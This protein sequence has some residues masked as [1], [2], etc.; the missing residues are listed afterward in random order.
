MKPGYIRY[1]KIAGLYLIKYCR[2]FIIKDSY[3]TFENKLYF[4]E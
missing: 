2:N 3:H 1:K 4:N